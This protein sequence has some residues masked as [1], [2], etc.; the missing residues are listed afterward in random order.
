MKII[1]VTA[2][3]KSNIPQYGNQKQYIAVHYLGVVGQNNKVSSGGYGAHFY[4]YYD[5]TVYQAAPLDAVL[6]QVGTGG[7]YTQKHASARNGNT[8]GIEMCVKCDG[9]VNKA[10]DPKWY[11]T[12]ATQKACVELVQYL[13]KQLGLSADRVLRH[14]D[15]VNK[16]CPAP[17]VNNNGYKGSWTWDQFKQ[18][19]SG[20]SA[21][22]G[23][24][25]S[26]TSTPASS[27]GSTY[28]PGTYKV[29]VASL[30]IR[31]GPSTKYAA[32]GSITDKGTYTITEVQ[33][34]CWGKLK[35]G[36]GWICID[37]EYCTRVGNSS[38]TASSPAGSSY[39]VSVPYSD[40]RIRSGPGTSYTSNGYIQPGTYTIVDTKVSDGH[41]WGK[42][43]S[44]AGWI[45]LEYTNRA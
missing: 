9:D 26:G 44:G 41:T 16:V 8:I 32:C 11:F 45:A 25:N 37:G 3:S 42:L 5:G 15:I 7:Y 31:T 1:D 18:K 6:W 14:Y 10:S 21:S 30:T 36:A 43:K 35:S 39:M 33:N 40:L 4:I 12:E 19:V 2:Q 38:G 17:Y 22:S 20:S 29:K 24:T 23:S 28:K 34:T 27:G 13:M